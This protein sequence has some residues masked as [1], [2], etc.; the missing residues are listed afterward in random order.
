[1]NGY[2]AVISRLGLWS[3]QDNLIRLT[4]EGTAVVNAAGSAIDA[5]R[6]MVIEIKCRDFLGYDVLFK[7]LNEGPQNLEDIHE[8]L[9]QTLAVDWKSKNQTTFRV[10]WLRSLGYAEKDG[11]VYRLTANGRSVLERLKGSISDLVPVP[12]P[13]LAVSD[14][15]LVSPLRAASNRNC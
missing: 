8:Y 11:R 1:M 14:T 3:H 7:L 9:K 10:N 12:A 13:S 15:H 5:A 2:I 4:P 6:Q